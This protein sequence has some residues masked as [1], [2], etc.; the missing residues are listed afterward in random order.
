ML[1]K[2]DFFAYQ[3]ASLTISLMALSLT[4]DNTGNRGRGS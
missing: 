2:D 1:V 3:I 4:S